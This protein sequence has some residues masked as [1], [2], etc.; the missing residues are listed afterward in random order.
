[1]SDVEH[2]AIHSFGYEEG[3]HDL[4]AHFAELD[5]VIKSYKTGMTVISLCGKQWV[6]SRDPDSFPKCGTCL[7]ILRDLSGEEIQ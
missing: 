1:M 2:I 7:S 4:L 3:D 6:P 5:E